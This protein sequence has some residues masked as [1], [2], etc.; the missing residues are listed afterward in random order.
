MK[1]NGTPLEYFRLCEIFPKVPPSVFWSFPTERMLKNPKK[2]QS[3]FGI[4]RLFFSLKRPPSIVF[5]NLRQNG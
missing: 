1:L 2:S 4:V 3:F 5:D